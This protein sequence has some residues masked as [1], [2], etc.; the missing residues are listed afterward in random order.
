MRLV[1]GFGNVGAWAA[2]IY[3]EQGGIVQAVS[4]AFGAIYNE[5]GL[6]IKAL[7]QHLAEGNMLDAFPEGRLT[8]RP[9][10]P[11]PPHPQWG[12]ACHDGRPQQQALEARSIVCGQSS[13]NTTSYGQK[14]GTIAGGLLAE[15]VMGC[16]QA[17]LVFFGGQPQARQGLLC[18]A[19]DRGRRMQLNALQGRRSTRS[20]SWGC[21]ATCWCQP[22][23]G[24]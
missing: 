17:S 1:Q 13:Q 22:P 6:D 11:T 21:R 20:P 18:R 15:S 5:K 2:E 3:Q 16:Q 9:P 12:R 10:T 4:D 24:A 8:L 23:S 19:I 7:R 14:T